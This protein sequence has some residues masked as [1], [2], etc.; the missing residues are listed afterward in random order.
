MILSSKINIKFIYISAI[1]LIANIFT[2]S[3]YSQSCDFINYSYKPD[4][5]Y[6][7]SYWTSTKKIATG[8]FHWK[9]K[10]WKIAG[11]VVVIGVALYIFDD[12]IRN[13]FQSNQ[14]NT[15]DFASKYIFEPLG[16]GV[17]PAILL[18]GYYVYGLS[19]KNIKARQIALG[20]TQAFLMASVSAQILKN[21]FHRHRPYQD[22]PPNPY[23]WEGPF[24]GWEY[25]SFPSGHT[26]AAFAVAT[27]MASVYKDK[28]WVGVLSYG[29][30]TGV[31]LSRI[32]DNMHW[33]SDVFIAAALGFAVGK[34]VYNIMAKDSKFSMGVSD[35]GG[36]SVAYKID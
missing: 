7:K 11:S 2:T 4:K 31:G 24:S 15:F 27:L 3:L 25:T 32:Y 22:N 5:Q 35:T 29:L 28:P 10:E 36:I 17:Y 18:G 23:L 16:S 21:V 1:L 33:S 12:E 30:A 6:I 9:K 14:N 34:T 19:A 26:T 13:F 20:G 8:P